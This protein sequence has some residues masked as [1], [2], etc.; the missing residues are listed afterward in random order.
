[1]DPQFRR[2]LHRDGVGFICHHAGICE[3]LELYLAFYGKSAWMAFFHGF[4]TMMEREV[5]SV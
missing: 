2:D 4:A 1:M 3:L 5:F